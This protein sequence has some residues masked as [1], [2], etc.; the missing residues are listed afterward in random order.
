MITQIRRKASIFIL[1]VSIGLLIGALGT[2][3]AD[4]PGACYTCSPTSGCV[5][6]SY[7]FNNCTSKWGPSGLASCELYGDECGAAQ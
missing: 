1:V 5:Q 4:R 2:S 3:L 6:V 7:G